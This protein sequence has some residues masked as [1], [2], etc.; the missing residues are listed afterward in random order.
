MTA[1]AKHTKT[2]FTWSIESPR[3]TCPV[4]DGKTVLITFPPSVEPHEGDDNAEAFEA[5]G[6]GDWIELR[7]EVSG[8]FCPECHK[9][10]S[11]SLNT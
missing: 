9:L 1:T 7:E 5:A 3:D 8:H 10:V 4:C 11:L 2:H 6:G